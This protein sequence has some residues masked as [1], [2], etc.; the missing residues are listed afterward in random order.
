MY[1]APN[2]SLN[3]FSSSL[4]L[5]LN[6]KSRK[7]KGTAISKMS[8]KEAVVLRKSKDDPAEEA[9]ILELEEEVSIFPIWIVVETAEF[10]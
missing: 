3:D 1:R 2:L 5:Y 10:K 7:K 4:D 6:K 9:N 8:S